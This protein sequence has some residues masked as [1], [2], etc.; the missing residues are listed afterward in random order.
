MVDSPVV[1]CLS[2]PRGLLS[3]ALA[4][5]LALVL[6]VSLLSSIYTWRSA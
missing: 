3:L 6:R 2:P 4:L 1:L 5:A